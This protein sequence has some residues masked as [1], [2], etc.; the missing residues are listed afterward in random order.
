LTITEARIDLAQ[1]AHRAAVVFGDDRVGVLR[2]V[3][4]MWSIAASRPSTMRIARI[5]ARYSVRQSSSVARHAH[6]QHRRGALRRRAARPL[7]A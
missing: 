5:G 4:A 6:R 7:V 3:A 2:A 1:E